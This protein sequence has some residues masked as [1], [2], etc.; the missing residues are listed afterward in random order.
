MTSQNS[1]SSQSSSTESDVTG[2][3]DILHSIRGAIERLQRLARAIRVPGVISHASK[4][5]KFHP[6]DEFGNDVVN[7]FKSYTLELITRKLGSTPDFLKQRLSRANASRRQLFLFRKRHQNVLSTRRRQL[8]EQRASLEHKDHEFEQ[9]ALEAPE[10]DPTPTSKPPFPQKAPE[11][12]LSLIEKAT[13]FPGSR[14]EPPRSLKPASSVGS[15]T[16]TGILDNARFPPPPKVINTGNFFECPYCCQ[17]TPVRDLQKKH[18][19]YAAFH[20]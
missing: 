3:E 11:S 1:S 2:V 14:F 20:L 13:T 18:W 19:R 9:D 6:K 17:L 12:K 7:A 10:M 5:V 16:M 8:P 15:S 4:A